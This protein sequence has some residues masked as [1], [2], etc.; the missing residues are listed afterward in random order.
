VVYATKEVSD[1]VQISEK[2]QQTL[3]TIRQVFREENIEKAKVTD[4]KKGAR[5][6]KSKVK[7]ILI[8]FFDSKGI[9]HKESMLAGQRANYAY[10]CDILWQL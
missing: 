4:T 10:Y 9:V 2:V 7:S 1:L 3:A 8:I 6:V 5:Q